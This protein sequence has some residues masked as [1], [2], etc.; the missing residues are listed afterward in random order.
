MNIVSVLFIRATPAKF[1][2]MF[3]LLFDSLLS[4]SKLDLTLEMAEVRSDGVYQNLCDE[5]LENCR[6]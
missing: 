4:V 3:E 6:N 1:S 5:N 2:C